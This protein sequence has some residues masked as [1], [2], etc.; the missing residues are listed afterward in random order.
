MNILLAMAETYQD[1]KGL[2]LPFPAAPFD[3]YLMHVPGREI[4]TRAK[5]DEIYIALQ[6]AD[7]SVLFDDR[8]ERAGVK[9]NDADLV[10][11]PIRVTIGEKHLKDGMVEL[12]L[13]TEKDNRLISFTSLTSLTS[14]AE[15][16]DLIKD[17]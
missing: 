11:C 2:T 9:F 13:R 4:D 12:K 16:W 6:S 5:A 14:P 7:V 8:D 1:N 3:V 10:G 15:F 17:K